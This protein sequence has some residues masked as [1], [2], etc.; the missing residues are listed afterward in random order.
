M[1]FVIRSLGRG[2][3]PQRPSGSH[4]RRSSPS[5]FLDPAPGLYLKDRPAAG[6]QDFQGKSAVGKSHSTNA[7]KKNACIPLPGL[8]YWIKPGRR[9]WNTG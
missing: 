6:A 5:A 7:A 8:I 2:L 3:R 4:C 1:Q 9:R